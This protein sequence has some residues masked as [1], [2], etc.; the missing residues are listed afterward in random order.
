M[1]VKSFWYFAQILAPGCNEVQLI[2]M[3]HI[4]IYIP[5]YSS[6]EY[7]IYLPVWAFEL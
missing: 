7:F 3:V 4:Y 6:L 2:G 1:F 5:E